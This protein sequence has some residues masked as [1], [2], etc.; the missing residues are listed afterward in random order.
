MKALDRRLAVRIGRAS[1]GRHDGLVLRSWA[2]EGQR[3][4][5]RKPQKAI[6]QIDV[7]AVTREEMADH[8]GGADR[9]ERMP[10]EG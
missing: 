2:D 9:P 3:V 1:L 8:V 6:P 4:D 5:D 7:G 10:E